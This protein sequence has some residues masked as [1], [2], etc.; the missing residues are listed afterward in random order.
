MYAG[1]YPEHSFHYQTSHL[2]IFLFFG[3]FSFDLFPCQ[4]AGQDIA[5]FLVFRHVAKHELNRLAGV[6]KRRR[7]LMF[8]LSFI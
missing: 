4:F 2:M 8:L 3:L 5:I 7:T 1:L 6:K